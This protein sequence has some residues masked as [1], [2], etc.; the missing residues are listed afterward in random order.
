MA[1]TNMPKINIP[2]TKTTNI[3]IMDLK[4]VFVSLLS[5]QPPRK[6]FTHNNSPKTDSL[7]KIKALLTREAHHICP[8]NGAGVA[9][10]DVRGWK[11]YRSV[12]IFKACC[13]FLADV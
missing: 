9:M 10:R 3:E 11:S 13:G 12:K 8:N 4:R 2:T 5:R 7:F 1:S 6:N